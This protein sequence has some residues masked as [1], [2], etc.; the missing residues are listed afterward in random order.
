VAGFRKTAVRDIRIWLIARSRVPYDTDWEWEPRWTV[1]LLRL[2]NAS[3]IEF[4]IEIGYGRRYG[5]G[6][7][8]AGGIDSE[9]VYFGVV[10]LVKANCVPT[11]LRVSYLLISVTK[12]L[13]RTFCHFVWKGCMGHVK[14]LDFKLGWWMACKLDIDLLVMVTLER[15]AENGMKFTLNI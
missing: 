10:S 8:V 3:L 4:H 7:R 14:V 11:L 1:K 12:L 15:N 5:D 2:H 6:S 9:T 13:D